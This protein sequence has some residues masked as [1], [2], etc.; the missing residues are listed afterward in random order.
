MI[1]NALSIKTLQERGY[2]QRPR[3]NYCSLISCEHN[4]E[5]N[6]DTS[7]MIIIIGLFTSSTGE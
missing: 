4:S 3:D 7:I 1:I 2:Q 6:I 5:V